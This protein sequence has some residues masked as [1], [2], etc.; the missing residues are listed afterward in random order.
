MS[1]EPDEREIEKA[2]EAL[3]RGEKSDLPTEDHPHPHEDKLLDR[4]TSKG[5]SGDDTLEW[6]TSLLK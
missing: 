3:R 2:V 1:A 4:R 6:I 5:Q